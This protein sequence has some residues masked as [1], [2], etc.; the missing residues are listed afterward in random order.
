MA[1]L[2]AEI[3]SELIFCRGQLDFAVPGSL[4]ALVDR[5]GIDVVHAHGYKADIYTYFAFRGRKRPA[6]VS[7]CHTWY[8]N[9]LA[10]RLYG[11]ADRW[12]LRGFDQVIAV[13]AEVRERLLRAG[14]KEEKVHLIQNGVT[15]PRSLLAT[16][17]RSGDAPGRVRVGLVGRLAPE[18]GVDLFLRA[19]AQLHGQHPEAD[20]VVAGDG[21]ERVSL[22]ALIQELG[23]QDRVKLLGQQSD[24]SAFYSSLD[25]LV[26]T[27]RQEGLPMAM[28]EGMASGLPVVA[29]AVGEVPR[30]V[31][32]RQT[33]LLVAP[34]SPSA[35]AAALGI[36]LN[37]TEL[38]KQYGVAGRQ[39][40]L[41]LFS[42][43]RMTADYVAVYRQA[44]SGRT[45]HVQQSPGGEG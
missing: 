16:G 18:K 8:D 7:T 35:I 25:L 9:D 28:L 26:S 38:R 5:L 11:A 6:L 22:T 27:S 2:R 40:V 44:L 32:D 12:V 10:V 15:V 1:A 13:S 42:A 17:M 31:Q 45:G 3:S 21:P 34:E 36:L 4:R 30:V 37:D 41:D 23:L 33:G 24:M 43:D 19:L 29:T 14:V 39:R 20:F